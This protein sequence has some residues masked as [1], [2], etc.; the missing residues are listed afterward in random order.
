MMI[1]CN[2][3]RDAIIFT[4]RIISLVN[5]PDWILNYEKLTKCEKCSRLFIPMILK[6]SLCE[7][8]DSRLQDTIKMFCKSKVDV[9]LDMD[10]FRDDVSIE[11]YVSGINNGAGYYIAADNDFKYVKD[12]F[13][14]GG[15]VLTTPVYAIIYEYGYEGLLLNTVAAKNIY[16]IYSNAYR[17]AQKQGKITYGEVD[18]F[19]ELSEIPMIVFLLSFKNDDGGALSLLLS[20]YEKYKKSF[21]K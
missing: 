14:R 13:Q 19:P 4:E 11:V 9:N 12:T 3:T 17:T 10:L 20:R 8:C 21:N 7:K 1:K 16:N 5:K 2:D 15:R 6:Q 18:V